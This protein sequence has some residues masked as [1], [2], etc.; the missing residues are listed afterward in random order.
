[1]SRYPYRVWSRMFKENFC[2]NKFLTPKLVNNLNS[3]IIIIKLSSN[4]YRIIVE[5]NDGKQKQY[6]KHGRGFV[7]PNY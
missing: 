7:K 5:E 2:F 6:A 4:Y 1:M 3:I